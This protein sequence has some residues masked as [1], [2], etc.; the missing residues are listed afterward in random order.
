M[1]DEGIFGHAWLVETGKLTDIG[2]LPGQKYSQ[3]IAI[4]DRGQVVGDSFDGPTFIWERGAIRSIGKLGGESSLAA[5][6]SAINDR[7]WIV[8]R[9]GVKE[10]SH[11]FVWRDGRMTDLGTLGGKFSSA[12]ALNNRGQIVGSAEWKRFNDHAFLWQ[13]G[14]MTDLGALPRH[15]E[16][17]AVAMRRPR[18]GRR[19]EHD[20]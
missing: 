5:F 3:G 17:T 9:S 8:G 20:R 1:T 10:G 7:G 18:A 16:S 12:T 13:R 2:A 6:A 15:P 11:A 19:L 4:N 14:R